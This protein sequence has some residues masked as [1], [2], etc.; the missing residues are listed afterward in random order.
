MIDKPTKPLRAPI[1]PAYCYAASPTYNA[2]VKLTAADVHGLRRQ[3][4]FEGRPLLE[5][6][7]L[8][9]DVFQARMFTF[10]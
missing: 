7:S 4:G 1:Y 10:T 6:L 3:P 5:T 8:C 2:W 9:T